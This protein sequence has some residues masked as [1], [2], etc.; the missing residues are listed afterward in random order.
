MIYKCEWFVTGD[1]C[2]MCVGGWFG[3]KEYMLVCFKLHC[4]IIGDS[5]RLVHVCVRYWKYCKG[6]GC[7]PS[8]KINLLLESFMCLHGSD[9]VLISEIYEY[10]QSCYGAAFWDW[11]C[12]LLNH[13]W[14]FF[15]DLPQNSLRLKHACVL[16][17]DDWV[18]SKVISILR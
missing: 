11:I 8:V 7:I 17:L 2:Y 14:L 5:K 18:F 16:V 10:L 4:S 12:Q 6:G 1:V 3:E 9:N 15:S 13:L